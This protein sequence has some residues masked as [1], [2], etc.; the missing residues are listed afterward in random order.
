MREFFWL[1]CLCVLCITATGCTVTWLQGVGFR[2]TETGVMLTY[3]SPGWREQAKG[4][5]KWTEW[6]AD[7]PSE[8]VAKHFGGVA[9]TVQALKEGAK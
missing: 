8:E 6:L 5:A 9:A 3:D 7:A 1:A 4:V 2:V